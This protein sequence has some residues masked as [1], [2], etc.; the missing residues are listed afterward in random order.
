MKERYWVNNILII[1]EGRL[2]VLGND[3]NLAKTVAAIEKIADEYREVQANLDEYCNTPE[4]TLK[5]K[6]YDPLTDIELQFEVKLKINHPEKGE[7]FLMVNPET[8]ERY[9]RWGGVAFA[10]GLI[11]ARSESHCSLVKG[12]GLCG[13]YEDGFALLAF[14]P[15]HQLVYDVDRRIPKDSP[16]LKGQ[17]SAFLGQYYCYGQTIREVIA[18]PSL[19]PMSEENVE[20]K[21]RADAEAEQLRIAMMIEAA[22]A[23]RLREIEIERLAKKEAEDRQWE[24]NNTPFPDDDPDAPYPW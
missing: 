10:W 12:A 13:E 1:H 17:D 7:L 3:L 22:E 15:V 11:S 14:Y 24:I 16:I 6:Y 18:V 19:D 4:I 8:A 5:P 2:R 23:D 20:A 21:A 9:A